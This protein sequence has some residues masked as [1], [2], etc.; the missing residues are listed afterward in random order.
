[1]FVI[2]IFLDFFNQD[3]RYFFKDFY[4]EVFVGFGFGFL[5]SACGN[6]ADK[7]DD[8]AKEVSQVSEENSKESEKASDEN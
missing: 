3:Y 2:G 4:K 7:A 5:L 8:G 1:M 6:E